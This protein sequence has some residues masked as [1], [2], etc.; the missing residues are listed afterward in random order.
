MPPTFHDRGELAADP[1]FV[2]RVRQ[3]TVKYAMYIVGNPATPDNDIRLVKQLLTAP[4]AFAHLF[5]V[6]ASAN[7]VALS[8]AP[9][10]PAT[11]TEEGDAA[12]SFV[13]EQQVWPAFAREIEP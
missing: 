11:D 3:A 12:L 1:V 8:G 10:D 4:D 6:A 13:V 9:D 7:D 5:A 2:V